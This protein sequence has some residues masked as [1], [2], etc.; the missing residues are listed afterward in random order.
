M[1]LLSKPE[2]LFAVGGLLVGLVLGIYVWR[3]STQELVSPHS[4]QGVVLS[5]HINDKQV[6]G[7]AP[8]WELNNIT[9]QPEL[10]NLSY[11]GL[12]LNPDGTLQ[13]QLSQ[14]GTEP[15]WRTFG[16]S[17]WKNLQSSTDT[18]LNITWVVLDEEVLQSILSE[19][20]NRNRAIQT[21]VD[22]HQ[23]YPQFTSLTIDFEPP[24]GGL[25]LRDDFTQF[26]SDLDNNLTD[27]SIYVAMYGSAARRA[28][29]WDLAALNNSVDY[30]IMMAYDYH[31]RSSSYAGPVA[32]L[33]GAGTN[34][35]HD[36]TTDLASIL[37]FLPT[38]KVVLGIPFYGYRWRVTA[39]DNLTTFS[40]TGSTVRYRIISDILTENNLT[41]FEIKWQDASLSPKL[42]Y[43][44]SNQ[45]YVAQ[46]ENAASI[47][48]KLSLVDQ[49]NLAGIAIWALGY[50]GESRDLWQPITE[51]LQ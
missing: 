5:H 12:S 32:P 23:T 39:P 7:F 34:W 18:P 20:E 29:I 9:L 45:T 40:G 33:G 50:E 25:E 14:G 10:S 2:L 11:F 3:A 17:R 8:Y 44:Q 43:Q 31:R 51:W 4:S 48:Q 28:Q 1:K 49:Q 37:Q 47:A 19:S 35:D 36:V 30:F 16:S 41:P 26:M 38:Q 6:L 13:T 21:M 27:K 22:F 15:G 42:I 46:F 24:S